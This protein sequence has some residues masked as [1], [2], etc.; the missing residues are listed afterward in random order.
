MVFRNAVPALIGSVVGLQ[1]AFLQKFFNVPKRERVPKVPADC[2]E[3][4][5]GFGLP[6][7]EDRWSGCHFRIPSGYQPAQRRSCNTTL[8]QSQR[9]RSASCGTSLTC[10]EPFSPKSFNKFRRKLPIGLDETLAAAA[11]AGYR[12]LDRGFV[13]RVS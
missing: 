8:H 12:N 11:L 3:N 4:K 10:A 6:A 2:A 9:C 5:D 13:L 1:A 7:L